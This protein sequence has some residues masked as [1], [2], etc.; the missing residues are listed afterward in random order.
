MK[1]VIDTKLLFLLFIL[2]GSLTILTIPEDERLGE[3]FFKSFQYEKAYEYLSKASSA[4]KA[5]PSTLAKLR[6]YYIVEG[7]LDKAIQMQEKITLILPKNTEELQMLIKLYTWNSQPLEVLRV[8][9]RLAVLLP[10]KEQLQ[11]YNQILQGYRWLKKYEKADQL[12]IKLDS[13]KQSYFLRSNLEYYIA[14]NN[15]EK[16]IETTNTLIELE[17]S[18]QEFKLLL[19]QGYEL[20]NEYS[21][22][23]VAYINYIHNTNGKYDISSTQIN[24]TKKQYERYRDIYEKVIELHQVL[25]NELILAQIYTNLYKTN[26]TEYEFAFEAANILIKNEMY[27][28]TIELMNSLKSISILNV[29]FRAA[30]NLRLIKEYKYALAFYKKAN[31]LRPNNIEV[32]DGLADT[33]E[34]LNKNEEALYYNKKILKLLNKK[35]PK[36]SYYIQ[37]NS[38]LYAQSNGTYSVD[39]IKNDIKR[40]EQK[41]IYLLEK[42]NKQSE[43]KQMLESYI[44]RYPLDL[45]AKQNLAY[46][47]DQNGNK[48]KARELFQNINQ[49]NPNNVDAT[50]YLVDHSLSTYNYAEA[51]SYIE[52]NIYK[53]TNF[54]L[55][56][57]SY[58]VAKALKQDDQAAQI[59]EYIINKD[60]KNIREPVID[61]RAECY[62]DEQNYQQAQAIILEYL[63]KNQSNQLELK[64]A[65]AY[66]N[67]YQ[68]NESSIIATNLERKGLNKEELK[69]LKIYISNK[70]VEAKTNHSWQSIHAFEYTQTTPGTL[71]FWR[72]SNTIKKNQRKNS[73][74]LNYNIYD[75]IYP[76]QNINDLRFIYEHKREKTFFS[77]YIGKNIKNNTK[78]I[79]G[80]NYNSQYSQDQKFGISIDLNNQE[81]GIINI[82][83]YQKPIY[84]QVTVNYNQL[85]S[86]DS[87]HTFNLQVRKYELSSLSFATYGTFIYEYDYYYTKSLYFGPYIFQQRRVDGQNNT[88]FNDNVSIIGAHLHYW[89]YGNTNSKIS[90]RSD[91]Y[92]GFD[93]ATSFNF[94]NYYSYT[95]TTNYK[96]NDKNSIEF[97]VEATKLVQLA[98]QSDLYRLLI[99]Y[100]HWYF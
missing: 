66:A 45:E 18:S 3:I 46:V 71:D 88:I 37:F 87:E 1:K 23:I 77:S 5:K 16:V 69:T 61:L 21:K 43:R 56:N 70:E 38:T 58:Y 17:D 76:S 20:Q 40:R 67:N 9:E 36:S 49:I 96:I 95:N 65:Y 48:E 78:A 26:P 10:P 62:T 64:L 19:A 50:I 99:L 57:R 68:I 83:D 82:F 13:T 79:I 4:P 72:F 47:Y 24:A 93:I 52:A 97:Q 100:N 28:E 12:A 25:G 34:E 8:K 31:K 7:Q 98:S 63:S 51:N 39:T 35:V 11:E 75:P 27:N 6:D 22:A 81:Y 32:L 73:Y 59:C 44:K 91:L 55:L 42:T 85:L 33:L 30:D 80:L 29:Q 84:D 89:H 2:L 86:T 90:N 53:K 54:D 92:T 41:I 94:I 60:I 74:G 14:T 15:L